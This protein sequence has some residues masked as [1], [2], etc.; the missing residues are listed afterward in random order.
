M[1]N[2]GRGGGILAELGVTPVI[3]GGG[4]NTMHSGSRPLPEVVEAME[5]MAPVFVQMDEW[6]I[7]AGREIA[8]LIGAPAATVTSGASGGLVVQTAAAISRGDPKLIAQLPLTDGLPNELIIQKTQRFGYDH[9]YLVAGARFVEVGDQNGCT[10]EQVEAAITDNTAAIIDLESGPR[11]PGDVPLTTLVEIAH[12]HGLPVLCDGA[13]KLPPRANLTRFLDEGADLVSFSGGKGVRGPQSTGILLGLPEWIEYARLC[14]APNATVARGLKVSKEEIAGLVAAVRTFVAV[15]ETAES[16]ANTLGRCRRSSMKW[17]TCRASIRPCGTMRL[18]TYR[19]QCLGSTIRGRPG[20]PRDRP[21]YAC[22]RPAGLHAP[23]GPG[24]PR[25][26]GRPV[27]YPGR[28]TR[29][30][31]AK[32]AGN[33]HTRRKREVTVRFE[34]RRIAYRLRS[35]RSR[36]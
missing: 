12:R 33:A 28:R 10:P 20:Q 30:C 13:S 19:M 7:A 23:R 32:T 4:P 24:R 5:A 14:N 18:T 16:A 26:L 34:R 11:K 22:R 36:V 8:Q 2:S 1:K 25:G 15:D 6:L 29:T 17:A 35:T 3:N 31:S 21:A 9:L 27:E